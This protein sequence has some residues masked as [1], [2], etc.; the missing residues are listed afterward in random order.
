MF[1]DLGF[2]SYLPRRSL[3]PHRVLVVPGYIQY[4]PIIGCSV[5][6]SGVVAFAPS[7]NSQKSSWDFKHVLSC[8]HPTI[9][10]KMGVRRYKYSLGIAISTNF[11]LWIFQLPPQRKRISVIVSDTRSEATYVD[12][13]PRRQVRAE[14]AWKNEELMPSSFGVFSARTSCLRGPYQYTVHLYYVMAHC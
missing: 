2:P 10:L 8:S 11:W 3:N 5:R 6:N 4:H 7:M 9:Q 14:N 1:L 12:D 13:M